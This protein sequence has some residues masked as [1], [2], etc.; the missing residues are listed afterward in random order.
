MKELK[1]EIVHDAKNVVFYPSPD[2]VTWPK[3]KG[4]PLLKR[5]APK[6]P[7]QR[8]LLPKQEDNN[9]E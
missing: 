5:L 1:A 3:D 2:R 8:P 9:N 7:K 4:S 6:R